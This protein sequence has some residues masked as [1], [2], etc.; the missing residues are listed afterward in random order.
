[1]TEEGYKRYRRAYLLLKKRQ[2]KGLVKFTYNYCRVC[3]LE[4]DGKTQP[5][6][7]GPLRYWDADDGWCIGSLCMN[8]WVDV[9][10]A[11]PQPGDH[12]YDTRRDLLDDNVNTDEDESLALY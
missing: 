9:F 7:Q 1:M 12:A 11:K 6:N 2:D 3:G 10:D 5:L 4:P 8:C